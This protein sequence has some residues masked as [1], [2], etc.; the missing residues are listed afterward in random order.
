MS[1]KSVNEYCEILGIDSSATPEQLK[2]AYRNRVKEWH[3]DRYLHNPRLQRKA[4][5]KL[6]EINEAYDRLQSLLSN[7]TDRPFPSSA[8]SRP[9]PG[10]SRR[11]A[12]EARPK[13]SATATSASSMQPSSGS[14]K[15]HSLWLRRA[16][17][18]TARDPWIITFLILAFA[19]AIFID[20]FYGPN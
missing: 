13:G 17:L 3:P 19:L 16:I 15:K 11:E 1:M 9:R 6:R 2:R 7:T 12:N 10:A 18:E 8:E 4:E 14:W 20:F 5:E